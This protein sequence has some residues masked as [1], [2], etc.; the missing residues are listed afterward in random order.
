MPGREPR[1][2]GDRVPGP[3]EPAEL[4]RG[5]APAPGRPLTH[6]ERVPA[7]AGEHGA[8]AGLGTPSCS[9]R[10]AARGVA[11][12][13]GTRSRP[14]SWPAPGGTWWSPPAPPRASRWRTSS[15]R[16][17]RCSPTRTG[18]R[19]VP[20][21]DQGAGRRPAARRRRPRPDGVRPA[22][23]DGDTPRAEREWIRQ[24]ARFVL[25]NPDMLHHGIL[26]GHAHW[27][28]FLRRLHVRGRRRVPHLPGRLRLARGARAAP[29]APGRCARYGAYPGVR[30]RLGDRR[31]TRRRPR[32]G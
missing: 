18:H 22:G 8:L 30:A 15:R 14:P 2:H 26:P 6:V 21:P 23:Y 25:T 24:H 32:A 9:R 13:G 5:C 17:P 7:R 1:S 10:F 3:A 29:A 16:C 28:G 12:P 4:L 31:A 19:A 27:S 20:V 11:A